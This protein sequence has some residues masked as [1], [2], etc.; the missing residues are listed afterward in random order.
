MFSA[1]SPA[2]HV[3]VL[4]GGAIGI[5]CAHYLASAG[6]RVTVVEPVGVACAASGRAGGF[7]ALD[8]CDHSPV[9]DLARRSFELHASLA[10]SLD[11]A[12]RYGYRRVP[13][14]SLS[15]DPRQVVAKDGPNAWTGPTAAERLPWLNEGRVYGSTAMGTEETTAQLSP[16]LFVSTLWA[17]T[18]RRWG[19]ALVE[20]TC[21]ALGLAVQMPGTEEEEGEAAARRAAVVLRLASG[22]RLS[23]DRVVLAMGPWTGRAAAA[24]GISA[25]LPVDGEKV[26][27]V[28]FSPQ[29]PLIPAAC[30]FLEFR[31]EGDEETKNV[32]CA[33]QSCTRG[34][35]ARSTCAARRSPVHRSQR[36]QPRSSPSPPRASG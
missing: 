17:E 7:L 18:Q 29:R 15:A 25:A 32:E 6:A 14:R 11:G 21:V 31:D 36:A 28:V 5:S 1:V 24:M 8:W 20:S 4:G 34:R 26:H 22:Q 2:L 23:A 3:V 19:A 13:T 30:L 10:A 16:A 9:R 27:S 35:T 12:A 33:R